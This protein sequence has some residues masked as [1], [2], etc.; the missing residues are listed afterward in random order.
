MQGNLEPQDVLPFLEHVTRKAGTTILSYYRRDFGVHHKNTTRSRIDIV[1][2]ADKAAEE[3]IM[4]AIQTE[5]PG[6][7]MITEETETQLTGAEYRWVIDPLDGTVNFAHGNPHFCISVALM[8]HDTFVAGVVFDPLREESFSALDGRGAFLNGNAARV[9]D[10]QSLKASIVATG[11][12]YDRATSPDTNLPEFAAVAPA[13][14]GVRRAGSAALDLAYVA[15]GRLD[16]FWEFKLKPWDMAAGMMLV[17][18]AG[19][20]ISNVRGEPV[21]I[22]TPSVLASNGRIHDALVTL[23]GPL[24]D[25]QELA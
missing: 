6:H 14:Q 18:E 16:G 24:R 12:P 15:S 19:G 13:V 23:L 8:R 2:D 3:V 4:D 20:R 25:R 1:T 11:F 17:M 21:G 7:D 22:E 5:F 9:S 10:A